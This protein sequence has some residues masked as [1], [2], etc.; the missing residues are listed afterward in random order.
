MVLSNGCELVTVI[1]K[2]FFDRANIAA[3]GAQIF[4]CQVVNFIGLFVPKYTA[5]RS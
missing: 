3:H 5:R 4:K 2:R 1:G